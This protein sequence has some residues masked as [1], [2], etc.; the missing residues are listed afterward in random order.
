M[1]AVLFDPD[2]SSARNLFFFAKLILAS[3]VLLERPL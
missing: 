1:A 3:R 2:I